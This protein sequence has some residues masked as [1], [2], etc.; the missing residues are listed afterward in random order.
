MTYKDRSIAGAKVLDRDRVEKD[1][2]AL[3]AM[4]LVHS[5]RPILPYLP[6]GASMEFMVRMADSYYEHDRRG[7]YGFVY[8]A[9]PSL[10]GL[11]EF[12][13]T[14]CMGEEL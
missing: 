10:D 11:K 9:A 14:Y 7:F 13:K 6:N 5:M 8:G 12:A 3:E 2:A 4:K 1:W